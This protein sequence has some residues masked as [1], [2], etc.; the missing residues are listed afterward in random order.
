MKAYIWFCTALLLCFCSS[1][2]AHH[3]HASLNKDDVR[4]Y[5]GVVTRYSWTMPHV[6]MKINAPDQQGVV[7]EYSVEMN[8]PPSMTKLGW[9]KDSFKPGDT[10]VWQGPHDKD[11]DRHYTGMIWAERGDGTRFDMEEAPRGEVVP[12]T[13][14]TGLW[15]RSDIGGF[16]PHYR[17]P[18]GWALTERG[19]AMVDGFDEDNNP[20]VKCTNPGP[21]KSMIV[22]YPISITRPDDK[23]IVLERELM[24]DVRI[25]HLDHH[26]EDPKRP[27]SKLGF[28]VGRFED[29]ELIVETTN[30]VADR[31]GT[32][33]G[34]DSST[35]KHLTER[36]KLTDGGTHLLAH[37]TVAD[38]VYLAEPITF[39]HR[40]KKLAERPVIQAPCTMEAAQLYLE[41]GYDEGKSPN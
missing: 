19:Q 27:P 13:D 4:T 30:F 15:K 2:F 23:H 38:P 31:W 12:S 40:W 6:F 16:Q 22:P 5:R 32:H 25:V 1:S 3:S 35:E 37:I 20:M 18:E 34:I 7:V 26:H 9:S 21:P 8:H 36:F 41:A 24:Q 10:I 28:S 14:F 39:L 17:P 11:P 33:T 29:D